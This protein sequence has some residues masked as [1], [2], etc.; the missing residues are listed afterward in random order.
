MSIK[1]G[2][3]AMAK[4]YAQML[5]LYGPDHEVTE[6][7]TMNQFFV[8]HN[9]NGEKEIIT[10]PLDGTILPGVTRDSI[11]ALC[12]QKG[13]FKVTERTF[14]LQ[15]VIDAVKENRMIE[16]FGAGTAAIVSPVEGFHY[17]GVDYKIPLDPK[18]PENRVG[19][20]TKW[21]ADTLMDIQYGVKEHPW[22][23]VVD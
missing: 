15:E 23:V 4:G 19:P 2:Q 7:G 12:R 9:K 8:W 16:S 11:L 6:V 21:I 3:E 20:L 13:E 10:A 18:K 17:A 22:S 14:K 5:W 1:A